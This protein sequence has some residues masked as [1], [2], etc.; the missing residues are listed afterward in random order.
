MLFVDS[1]STPLSRYSNIDL[2]LI[3]VLDTYQGISID[4]HSLQV[5]HSSAPLFR[6]GCGCRWYAEACVVLCGTGAETVAKAALVNSLYGA[7]LA[8]QTPPPPV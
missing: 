1:F 2:P 7:Q 5:P 4:R 6:G 8:Q 3:L